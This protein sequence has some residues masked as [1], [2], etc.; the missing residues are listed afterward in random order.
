M[1]KGKPENRGFWLARKYWRQGI[2]TE[3]VEPI[4]S[5]AFS[6]LGFEKL[7]FANAVGNI[8][9]KRVKEKSGARLIGIEPAN[10]VDPTYAEHEIWELTKSE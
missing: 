10:F 8:A 7:I 4:V 9:S 3:A 5:Y 6:D 2:M 1:R